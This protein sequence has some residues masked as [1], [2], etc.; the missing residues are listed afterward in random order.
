MITSRALRCGIGLVAALLWV[1][2]P[3]RPALAQEITANYAADVR[4]IQAEIAKTHAAA[5]AGNATEA[6]V[7]MENT[8]RLW[9]I[10]RQ[11]N[12]D[13]RP[14]DPSFAAGLIKTEEHLFAA[15]QQVDR[16]QWKAAAAELERARQLLSEIPLTTPR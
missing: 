3:P 9:R 11:R 2:A 4:I 7:A 12:I 13:S 10:F 8:F 5:S 6:R 14:K 1:A 16:Q 15:T